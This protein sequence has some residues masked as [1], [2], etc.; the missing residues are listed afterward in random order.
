MRRERPVT[1][2]SPE[3]YD[4][5]EPWDTVYSD[6]LLLN[7]KNAVVWLMCIFQ[8]ADGS[9]EM[10]GCPKPF[11]PV[12][13]P[14]YDR[15]QSRYPSAQQVAFLPYHACQFDGFRNA[16][17]LTC[18]ALKPYEDM[19]FV[20]RN[21]RRFPLSLSE[22]TVMWIVSAVLGTRIYREIKTQRRLIGE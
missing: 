6:A 19:V 11:N 15:D 13:L 9:V 10:T 7:K 17:A 3:S 8:D 18:R 14:L 20:V 22:Y 12:I 1:G 4:I 5:W 2:P 16:S 21:L